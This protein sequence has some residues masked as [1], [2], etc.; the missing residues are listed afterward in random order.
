MFRNSFLLYD[1]HRIR[2]EIVVSSKNTEFFFE[3][4]KFPVAY[5]FAQK[6]TTNNKQC[7]TAHLPCFCEQYFIRQKEL[8]RSLFV[9]FA[10]SV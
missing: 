4:K 8:F 7:I 9:R 3:K 5:M 10:N 2:I 1:V 6:L